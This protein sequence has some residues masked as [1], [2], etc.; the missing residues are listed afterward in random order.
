MTIINQHPQSLH[1]PQVRVTHQKDS[2]I[3]K[4]VPLFSEMQSQLHV[5][6][7]LTPRLLPEDTVTILLDSSS[8]SG[9]LLPEDTVSLL[10]G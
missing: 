8:H 9:F 4:L 2:R 5:T 3:C 7:L 6:L 1:S 10:I